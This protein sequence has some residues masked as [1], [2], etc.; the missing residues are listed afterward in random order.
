VA[1]KTKND[2]N[3][4]GETSRETKVV[5]TM[6]CTVVE[7][8]PNGNLLIRGKRM[9]KV[10]GE[11]QIITLSGIARPE[12]IDSTNSIKSTRIADTRITYYGK[13]VVSDKQKPGWMMR[14]F[15]NVWPF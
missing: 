4:T 3:G 6:T 9:I 15:D 5:S 10:N 7:S 12:D 13:G 8:Y 2:F 14:A 11:E 1:A